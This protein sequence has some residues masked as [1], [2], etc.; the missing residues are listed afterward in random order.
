MNQVAEPTSRHR[1]PGNK[2]RVTKDDPKGLYK[3]FHC[4]CMS[5]IDGQKENSVDAIVTD[6]PYA[7]QEYE[8]SELD[9]LREGRGGIWRIPPSFDGAKR[10]AL[11][12]FSIINDD[13]AARQA[14]S[15]FFEAW[16]R[17]ALRILKPGGHI[18]IASTQLLSDCLG[19][20]LRDAGFERRGELVRLV[21]TLRGGDRP[22]GAEKEFSGLSVTPRSGWEPWGI[23]RKP[24]SEKTVAQNLRKWGTG[25]LRRPEDDT[26]FVDVVSIGR[27]P[28]DERILAGHP[29]QKPLELMEILV[30]AAVPNPKGLLV[31]PFLGSGVT[32]AAA[33]YLGIRSIGIER[34]DVFY[35]A[36]VSSIPKLVAYLRKRSTKKMG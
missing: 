26:P 7:V 35:K 34:D 18:I 31:E 19:R 23:Y 14:F 13:A 5:W 28:K 9:K 17:K 2:M 10:Q 36:A 30:R 11:P 24:L 12:R 33:E 6:P 3:L 16:G 8:I 25:A 22:K 1:L 21:S 27:T 4:D 32:V 20:A 29:S 15:N